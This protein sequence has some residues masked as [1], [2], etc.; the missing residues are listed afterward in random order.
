MNVVSIVGRLGSDPE[1]R[2]ANG[3]TVCNFS[4][5][6]NEGYGETKTTLWHRIVAW[7]KTAK[8][9]GEY[10]KKGSMAA[11]TGRLA[12]RSYEK[13]GVTVYVTEIIASNVEFLTPKGADN[14]K[15]QIPTYDA[16]KK[17]APAAGKNAPTIE[18][19]DDF[20]IPF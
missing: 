13:Q 2:D 6:T 17:A 20:P 19:E 5:A 14:E 1:V 16:P 18:G 12:Q 8:L 7:E 9:C 3:K 4:L 10:L 11:V 15:D